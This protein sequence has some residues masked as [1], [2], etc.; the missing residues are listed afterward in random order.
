MAKPTGKGI[1]MGRRRS[2]AK[3]KYW[4][5]GVLKKKKIKNMMEVNG[6]T[7][8]EAVKVWQ[9]SKSAMKSTK[10]ISSKLDR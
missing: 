8:D 7:Y 4:G 5:T 10:S 2:P 3:I 6:M 9:V 1:N